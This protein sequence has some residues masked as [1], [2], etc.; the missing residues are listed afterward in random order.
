MAARRV[1][2]NGFYLYPRYLAF[3]PEQA[4]WSQ[5][6]AWHSCIHRLSVLSRRVYGVYLRLCFSHLL[7]G[8]FSPEGAFRNLLSPEGF[9][10]MSRLIVYH[11]S[12]YPERSRAKHIQWIGREGRF[13]AV[14]LGLYLLA[15]RESTAAKCTGVCVARNV[16]YFFASRGGRGIGISCRFT[17]CRSWPVL[18]VSRR[19]FLA[20]KEKV[21]HRGI[22]SVREQVLQEI[23]A[24]NAF[25][26][27]L[28]RRTPGS[29]V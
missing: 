7:C 4:E 17:G 14:L 11:G 25:D 19:G 28:P 12:R 2:A 8:V 22:L 1:A 27:F 3:H 13:V 5:G 15:A 16:A 26:E 20:R 24:M 6:H 29:R 18:C 21:A 23:G 9:R 10:R